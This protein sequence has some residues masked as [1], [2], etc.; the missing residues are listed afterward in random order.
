MTA[1]G[2]GSAPRTADCSRCLALCCVGPAFA[3]SAD[4]A[5]DKPAHIPCPHLRADHACGIHADLP[6]RGFAQTS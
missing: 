3:A 2:A 6:A 4:F 1:S 5:L